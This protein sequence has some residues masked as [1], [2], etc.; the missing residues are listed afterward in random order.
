M[1]ERLI[2]QELRQFCMIDLSVNEKH[3]DGFFAVT[4]P[5][6]KARL[7]TIATAAKQETAHG[8][9]LA[10]EAKGEILPYFMNEPK[11]AFGLIHQETLYRIVPELFANTTTQSAIQS[12][13]A[14]L[15]EDE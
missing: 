7:V 12:T 13:I 9:F 1:M 11:T 10:L 14:R 8:V 15:K 3:H 6:L 4:L 5:V 2:N